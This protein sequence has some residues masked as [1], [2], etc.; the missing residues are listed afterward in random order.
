MASRQGPGP[1]SEEFREPTSD[2]EQQVARDKEE[3]QEAEGAAA[4]VDPEMVAL[5]LE[6]TSTMGQVGRQLAVIGDDINRRYDSEFQSMLEQ[7]Q[8]TAANAY[9]L[10]TKIAS[11]AGLVGVGG[12]GPAQL[13]SCSHSPTP[14][15]PC[16]WTLKDSGPGV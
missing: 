3:K 4:P 7:L 1:P 11:R 10:F 5:A 16:S 9:E 8:P 12:Q 2:S 6:P 13:S 14:C 15:W